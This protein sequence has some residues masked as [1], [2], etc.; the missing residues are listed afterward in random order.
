MRADGLGMHQDEHLPEVGYWI[1][2]YLGKRIAL[3]HVYFGRS[4]RGAEMDPLQLK[5]E[6]WRIEKVRAAQKLRR[7]SRRSNRVD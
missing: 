5:A 1:V 6:V 3:E 4:L 2:G 7:E